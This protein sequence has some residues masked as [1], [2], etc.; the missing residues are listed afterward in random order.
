MPWLRRPAERSPVVREAAPTEHSR[1]SDLGALG[2]I[3]IIWLAMVWAAHSRSEFPLADDWA[4][5]SSVR[6]LVERGAIELRPWT[7]AITLSHT[8]WGAVVA[9]FFGTSYEVLHRSILF[10]GLVGG[11]ATYGLLR[12]IGAGPVTAAVAAVTLIVN[13]LYFDL[14]GTFMTDVS[15]LAMST[16]ALWGFART[17]RTRSAAAF[18]LA[19]ASSLAAVLNRQIGA[20]LPASFAVAVFA[21]RCKGLR[22]RAVLLCGLTAASLLLWEVMVRRRGGPSLGTNVKTAEMVA[23]LSGPIIDVLGRITWNVTGLLLYLGLF[24]LPVLLFEHDTRSPAAKDRAETRWSGMLVLAILIACALTAFGMAMPFVG[25]IWIPSGIGP[26]TLR[27]TL[28]LKLPHLPELPSWARWLLTTASVVGSLCLLRRSAEVATGW[29]RG[30][31]GSLTR[32][33]ALV[34]ASTAAL[35]IAPIVLAPYFDRYLLPI[36]PIVL[37]LTCIDL[38]ERVA[39]RSPARSRAAALAILGASA[40]FSVAGVHD[41]LAWN[42][43]R[44]RA[45]EWLL[46]TG[47]TP[48]EFD[49]GFEWNGAHLYDPAYIVQSDK[50]WWWVKGDRWIVAFGPL[51]GRHLVHR[52]TFPRWLPPGG[53]GEVVVLERGD[54]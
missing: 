1:A 20:A 49:G 45:C 4:Y 10:L 9:L 33:Q 41:Y 16:A 39:S 52:E 35:Y 25:N 47:A 19:A 32:S 34:L 50:S 13:P 14:A 53:T 26:A 6:A 36:V 7:P 38:G 2:L 5:A 17:L 42:A 3:T 37:A 54:A 15:F 12:E 30:R 43:A 18:W 29:I 21:G 23:F 11:V 40:A 31:A 48:A 27:D 8:I 28:I 46:G 51:E 24:C 44:W 22:L